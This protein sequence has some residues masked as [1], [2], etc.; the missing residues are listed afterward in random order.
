[1][2]KSSKNFRISKSLLF[3]VIIIDKFKTFIFDAIASHASEVTAEEANKIILHNEKASILN[4]KFT[5]RFSP[6][7][8]QWLI[9]LGQKLIFDLLPTEQINVGLTSSFM[10]V[11]RKSISFAINIGKVVD[12]TLGLKECKTCKIEDCEYRQR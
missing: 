8:C 2:E 9:D 5:Q 4:K 1:M 10:M 7:Y 11:P 3:K 12:Q 6:E